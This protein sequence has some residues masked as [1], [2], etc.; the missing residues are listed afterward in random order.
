MVGALVVPITAG[1]DQDH[2]ATPRLIGRASRLWAPR[3]KEKNYT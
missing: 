3:A 1:P 2:N